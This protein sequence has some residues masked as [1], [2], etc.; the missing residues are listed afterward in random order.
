MQ[1]KFQNYVDGSWTDAATGETLELRNPADTTDRVAEFQKSGREDVK[2]AVEAANAAQSG[3]ADT[4]GPE[5]GRILRDAAGRL[6]D[7]K[8]ELAE[9][10]T[11]EEGKP[12]SEATGEVQRAIDIFYYCAEKIRD[13]GG[14][15]KSPSSERSTLYTVEE[16]IGV[17]GLITPWNYPIAIPAWKIAPAL[18]TGNSIVFKPAGPAPTVGIKLVEVLDEAGI[19][20]GV[21]NLVTGPGSTVGDEI[22]KNDGI[23]AV[24]FTG[25]AAVG[26][27]IYESATEEGKRAQCEMGGKNPTVV[28][29]S[30]DINQAVS[31]VANG[32]FGGTGQACT[33]CSRAI[34]HEDV[35]GEFIERIVEH[36]EN[37]EVGPGLEDYDM[38]PQINENEKQG[39]LD[40]VEIGKEEGATLETE[41]RSLDDQR[42]ENGF[43]VQPAVF[44]DVSPGMRIAQEE[45]FGPV[46]SVIEVSD[47]DEAIEVSNNVAYGLSSSIVTDDHTEAMQFVSDIEAGVA[48]IN[49]KTTGLELHVSFGGFKHSST[50][51]WREQGDAGFDF[52]TISKTVYDSYYSNR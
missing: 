38:G 51:T 11:R 1:S 33:A 15:V 25:S 28:M 42:F 20:D 36:A 5:R 17:A 32:A 16:P 23:N 31:I 41:E 35:H 34:V 10:L 3:W 8:D 19:P 52:Y 40:Y 13:F 45:I 14:K 48:K 39:T 6:A 18:A 21:M 43:F 46:L 30:A 22:V 47:Y 12:L 26:N 4:P 9:T 37:I 7:R 49:K 29:P 24:S 27:Q 50:E 44:S 2:E